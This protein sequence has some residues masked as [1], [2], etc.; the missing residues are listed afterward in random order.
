MAFVLPIDQRTSQGGGRGVSRWVSSICVPFI[1]G[2]FVFS[3]HWD[4]N[5]K[6]LGG[7]GLT[8][9]QTYGQVEDDNAFREYGEEE[10]TRRY[11]GSE[12]RDEATPEVVHQSARDWPCNATLLE[13]GRLGYKR[14]KGEYM[15]FV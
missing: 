12:N 7:G 11:K 9:A 1:V 5:V 8:C 14:E 10:A 6:R 4:L 2:V 15:V 13:R 3:L